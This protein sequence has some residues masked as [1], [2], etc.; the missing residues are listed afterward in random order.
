MKAVVLL[1]GGLDSTTCMAIAAKEN[2]ELTAVSIYYGQR[3][4]KEIEAAKKV[5][6]HYKA[7]ICEVN[8]PATI[9]SASD[10]PL[11]HKTSK[12]PK[13]GYENIDGLSPMYVPYRNGLMVSIAGAIA[14]ANGAERVYFGAHS[15]DARNFAY[16]DTTPEF[17]GSQASALY[18]GSG[19]KVRLITPLQWLT[20]AEI[21]R[22]GVYYKVPFNLT[23]SCYEGGD[24]ACGE[25][26]TCRSRLQAFEVNQLVDPI[27]YAIGRS[28]GK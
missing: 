25:C 26:P 9:F 12:I 16:P 27:P 18:I 20:K 6:A 14:T 15:E 10:S 21:V 2:D 13:I 28:C 23:W 22:L 19:N 17:I 24:M 4:E 11:L 8:L 7:E 5:A 1:S 3:H